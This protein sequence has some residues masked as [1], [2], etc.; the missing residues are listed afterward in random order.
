MARILLDGDDIKTTY[1]V[2]SL[3][4]SWNDLAKLPDA[5]KDV[6]ID[7]HNENSREYWLTNRKTDSRQVELEFLIS[8]YDAV[9]LYEFRDALLA[10]LMEDGERELVIAALMRTFKLKYDSCTSA[11]YIKGTGVKRFKLR[12]K[13]TVIDEY[14]YEGT[15]V[16]EEGGSGGMA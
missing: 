9:H 4:G 11:N 13:F 12:L 3:R 15:E 8:S 5:K 6:E 1:G 7:R 16:T 10:K 14:T 2:D